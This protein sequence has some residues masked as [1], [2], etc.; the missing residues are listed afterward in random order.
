MTVTADTNLFVYALDSRDRIKQAAALEAFGHLQIRKAA[1]A[2][3]VVGEIQNALRRRL[4]MPPATACQH[5]RN[6]FVTFDSFAF[7]P[8]CVDIALGLAA[9]GRLS[10]WDALLLAA[11]RRAGM[12]VLLSE[13]MQDGFEFGGLRVINPFG[14]TG[15]SD[16]A[17][18]ALG[19]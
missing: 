13:D 4:K 16:R 1:V 10:Y 2:L 3:Q 12:A 5:A 6:V 8:E 11:A 17:R 19:L 9:A 15:L 14:E 18:E 7:D